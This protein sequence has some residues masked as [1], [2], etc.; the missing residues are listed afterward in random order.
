MNP[1]SSIFNDAYDSV[2]KN[3]LTMT[4]GESVSRARRILQAAKHNA[5]PTQQGAAQAAEHFLA[6][7]KD[8][9]KSA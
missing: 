2:Y 3:L 8:F 4:Y 5:S 9:R 7:N 6:R 1:K